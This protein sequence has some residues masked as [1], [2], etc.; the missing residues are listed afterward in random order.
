MVINLDCEH[1]FPQSL[2]RRC[3]GNDRSG[4]VVFSS[5]GG[6]MNP[7]NDEQIKVAEHR[8]FDTIAAADEVHDPLNGLVEKTAGDPGAPFTPEV[9][10]PLLR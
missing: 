6:Q 4:T 7:N 2:C 5:L 1:G 10:H 9:W 8:I 3:G